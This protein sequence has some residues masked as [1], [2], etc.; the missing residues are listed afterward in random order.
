[1]GCEAAVRPCDVHPATAALSAMAARPTA[2][3]DT[4]SS[5]LLHE[6][7]SPNNPDPDL[8]SAR[9]ITESA[10]MRRA[11]AAREQD[12]MLWNSPV[13]G[14]VKGDV[15]VLKGIAALGL[16]ASLMCGLSSCGQYSS[17]R[18]CTAVGCTT[19]AYVNLSALPLHPGPKSRVTV[20][21][22]QHCTT[23]SPASSPL[24]GAQA[25]APYHDE[26]VVTVTIS[27]TGPDGEVLAHS[28]VQAQLHRTQ[29]NGADCGPTCY[30]AALQL[31]SSGKL[32]VQ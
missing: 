5:K 21:V 1:M 3:L 16:L 18:G 15:R 8:G 7:R 6:E 4:I 14:I 19:G 27:M 9:S 20:C 22:D 26:R 13:S 10:R 12:G 23:R 30:Y 2:R 32:E 11:F 24:V 31:T 28:S 29:P 17:A 25:D